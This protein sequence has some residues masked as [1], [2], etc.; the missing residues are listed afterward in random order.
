[1]EPV[2]KKS[3]TTAVIVFWCL[4]LVGVGI[5]DRWIRHTNAQPTRHVALEQ[6]LSSLPLE[7]GHWK[8]VDVPIDERILKVAGVDDHVSRRYKNSRTG[9]V[10]DLYF[11]YTNRPSNMLGHR[12]SVCYPSQGWTANEPRVEKVTLSDGSTLSYLIHHFTRD[13]PFYEGLV[14]LN[15]YILQGKHTTDWTDFWSPKWRGANRAKNPNFYVAQVQ[16]A[17]PST[18]PLLYEPSEN[19]VKQFAVEVAPFVDKLLPLTQQISA[20]NTNNQTIP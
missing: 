2:T 13:E 11:A 9:R 6:P 20:N 1:M 5:A 15:Y 19:I 12:P 4:I 7:F 3:K 8:G 16:I 14:V 10:V 17:A 18:L